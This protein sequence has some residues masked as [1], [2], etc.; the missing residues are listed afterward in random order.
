MFK[1]QALSSE[2]LKTVDL[3]VHEPETAAP[4]WTP[5]KKS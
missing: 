4:Y 5:N 1:V 3:Q 2:E